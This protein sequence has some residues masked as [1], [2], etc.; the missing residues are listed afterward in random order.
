MAIESSKELFT[1]TEMGKLKREL[2]L[3]PLFGLIYFTVCGGSFGIEALI[4]WSGPG[5]ALVLIA[6]I[7][8]F[9]SIPNML[10]VREMNSMMPVEGG[11]YHWVKQAFGRFTGYMAGWMNWVVSWVDVSIYPILAA[12]YL[13]YFIPALRQGATIGG[14]QF[15]ATFLSWLVA[16]I[17]I[18]SISYLNM[19]GARLAGLT[20]NW[21]GIIM[22]I[23]LVL[24][25]A[26]GIYN[27]IKGGTPTGIPFLP[28][29]ET[30]IGAIST[31]IFVVMWNYMG[32]ELPTAAGSEIVNPKKTY[33]R[34]MVLVLVAAVLT[35]SIPAL[36][37][38]YG[39]AGENGRY[40]V[41]GIEEES[42]GAGI[43]Q[44]MEGYG[45][46]QT[47]IEQ[48][49]IDPTQPAGWEFPDI[50]HAIG[51]KATGKN[52]PL[53]YFLGTTVMIA[54]VLAMIGLFIGNGLGGTRVPFAMA[55]DGMMPRFL[56]KVHPKYGTPWVAILLCGAF[57]TVFSLNAFASLVVIDV[58]LN[59]LVLMAEFF[60]LWVMRFKRP[61]LQRNKVPYGYLG[62]I[63][64]TLFP[65]II[66]TVAIYSQ[67]SEEGFNSIGWALAAMAIGA[68]L[69]IPIRK[70]VKP[71][72][73]DIDPY[74]A[75]PAVD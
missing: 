62:L 71:G 20:T 4:G 9:F 33:P 23:P 37:G 46:S 27:W 40:Q 21:L 34:A 54:A 63:Y 64:V 28:V 43:G 56:T 10:M 53:S 65:L 70:W 36:A 45:V 59:M 66:V 58:F 19:R 6:L 24:M 50:A 16:V 69:Y 51:E 30:A 41:W 42:S 12:Y 57:Y 11:Y 73:P 7:P 15:S 44:V 13:G 47:Q 1:K 60:A 3:L 68:L 8:L 2:T 49:G 55:E 29:G 22:I 25:S 39:G 74:D 75:T 32:W 72:V 48:I 61:E 67:I 26:V 14:I 35:Y 31:G 17:L 52:S 18:W 5:L 38:L